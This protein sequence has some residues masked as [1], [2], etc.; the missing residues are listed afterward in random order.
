LTFSPRRVGVELLAELDVRE[1]ALLGV[2]DNALL[3]VIGS[4]GM[5]SALDEREIGML[6]M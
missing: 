1:N 3:G 5:V 6:C 2:L 4:E